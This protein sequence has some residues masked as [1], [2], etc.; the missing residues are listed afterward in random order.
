[1][2]G[3]GQRGKFRLEEAVI[4]AR[5]AVQQHQ[6]GPLHHRVALGRQAAALNVE[7]QPDPIH[8]DAYRTIM[9]GIH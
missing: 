9:A 1:L 5:A 2:R 6:H 3:I 8:H 7:V 4:G